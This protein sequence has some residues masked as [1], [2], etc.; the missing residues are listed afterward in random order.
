MEALLSSGASP[1][2]VIEE[3]GRTLLD[4]AVHAASKEGASAA[5]RKIQMVLEAAVKEER[6]MAIV[7]V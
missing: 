4:F 2:Q 3:D 6:C 5:V 1:R 7:L